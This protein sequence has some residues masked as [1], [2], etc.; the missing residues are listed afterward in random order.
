MGYNFNPFTIHINHRRFFNT[1][2]VIT[3][4]PWAVVEIFFLQ[5]RWKAL[6]KE[7]SNFGREAMRAWRDKRGGYIL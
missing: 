4:H 5:Y 3:D 7:L 6:P 2:F 1:T